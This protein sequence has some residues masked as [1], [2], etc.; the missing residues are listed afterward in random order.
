MRKYK[1]MNLKKIK[2]MKWLPV[3]VLLATGANAFAQSGS[4]FPNSNAKRWTL[5]VQGG[6]TIP[7]MDANKPGFGC[8][9]GLNTQYNFGHSFGLRLAANYGQLSATR[10]YDR[11]FIPEYK[12]KTNFI[13]FDL[14]AVF[15]LGNISNLRS[16]RKTIINIYLGAGGA[17]YNTTSDPHKRSVNG[18]DLTRE[19]SGLAPFFS[20]GFGPTINLNEKMA[21]GINYFFRYTLID[22]MDALNLG[23]SGDMY[24]MLQVSLNFKLGKGGDEHLSFINPLETMYEDIASVKADVNKLKGDADGDGVAD[25]FDKDPNTPAGAKV[26]GNGEAV[27]SDG[28][29][30]ADIKDNEPNSPKGA[31]VDANG[32]A[33]DQDKDG[34]ADVLD[35]SPDTDPKFL[36]NHQGIPIM[37]KEFAEKVKKNPNIL[38]GGVGYLP[39][40]MFETNSSKV[41]P[42]SYADLASIAAALKKGSGVK[43]EIIGHADS[44]GSEGFNDKLGM[45]RAEAVKNILIEMGVPAEL[46]VVKSAGE[47]NPL[48]KGSDAGSLAANRRVEFFISE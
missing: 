38:G 42:K 10:D 13:D 3:A 47:R 18:A 33:E 19:S 39:A 16:A 14:S 1:A 4:I 8:N 34:V 24:H 43:L 30:V 40:I 44:R 27:D 46:L 28:D 29:G 23:K 17:S 41:S 25:H 15:T 20:G 5:G 37:T 22:S 36:V 35:L 48:L 12:F 7:S 26:Y 9:A 32:V 45:A 2:T 11:S 6:I 31:K 21:L